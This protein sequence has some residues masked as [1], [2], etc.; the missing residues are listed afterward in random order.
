MMGSGLVRVRPGDVSPLR[1]KPG[2]VPEGWGRSLHSLLRYSD[3]QTVAGT[4]AVFM[5]IAA[6]GRSLEEFEKWGVVS[7]T[8]FLGRGYLAA[9][10]RTFRAEGVWGISPHLI[11]HY[12]LHSSSGTISLALGLHGPNLGVGGGA[13]A[14]AEG[15]LAALTWLDCGVVPGVWLVLSGWYPEPIP[16]WTTDAAASGECQALALALMPAGTDRGR[17]VI[18]VIGGEESAPAA[19]PA[20]LAGLAEG[21]ERRGGPSPRTIA[22]DSTGWIRVEVLEGSEGRE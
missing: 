1:R 20:D 7:A 15:A 21:F 17:P 22:T 11:P 16:D 18:R 12:A 5:A 3:E 19:A 13:R 2:P 6:M 14:P 4:A 10:L 8:R 9:T